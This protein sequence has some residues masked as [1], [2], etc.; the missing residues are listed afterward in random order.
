MYR[1]MLR[2]SK[3]RAALRGAFAQYQ[4]VVIGNG[5]GSNGSLIVREV[6]TTLNTTSLTVGLNG[7]G[8]TSILDGA[9]VVSSATSAIG[10]GAQSSGTLTVAGPVPLGR[11]L[12]QHKDLPLALTAVRIS[13]FKMAVS[14]RRRDTTR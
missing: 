6:N 7:I 14:S 1:A 12:M 3:L 4:A 5:A 13:K 2:R 8:S 9:K 11:L 10:S